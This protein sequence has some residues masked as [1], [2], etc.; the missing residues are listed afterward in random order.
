M[1]VNHE[2]KILFVHI[3]KTGGQTVCKILNI[4]KGSKKHYYWKSDKNEIDYGHATI[5]QLSELINLDD[6]YKFT[7]IR[8]PYDRLVSEY[9]FR[10]KNISAKNSVL[11][12]KQKTSFNEFVK[13]VYELHKRRFNSK[14]YFITH[15]IPQY[16]YIN[17]DGDIKVDDVY[18]Y[19]EFENNVRKIINEFNL[20]DE[21]P[22]KNISKNKKSDYMEYYNME[23]KKM[24]NEI[25]ETDFFRFNYNFD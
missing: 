14:H 17:I 20:K 23:T 6:Y 16:D 7:F 11:K 24:V 8:N 22:K 9:F 4:P 21:I 2:H 15:Y 25:Y 13:Q 18:R 1:P 10:I 12:L 3:P 19:E 5:K